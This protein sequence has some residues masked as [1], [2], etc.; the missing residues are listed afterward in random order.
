MTEHIQVGGQIVPTS[1]IKPFNTSG[2]GTYIA[3]NDCLR[4]PSNFSQDFLPPGEYKIKISAS[5]DLGKVSKVYY[6]VSPE[7]PEDLWMEEVA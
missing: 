5:S 4:N 6:L 1:I 7:K 3:T 2:K